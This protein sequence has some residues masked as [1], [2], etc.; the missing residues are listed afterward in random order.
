MYQRMNQWL[1]RMALGLL[2]IALPGCITVVAPTQEPEAQQQPASTSQLTVQANQGWQD[3]GILVQS[4]NILTVKYLSGQ[5]CAWGGGCFDGLGDGDPVNNSVL[6]YAKHASLI[7]RIG[8]NAPFSVGNEY[9]QPASQ[10]GSLSLRMNDVL[11]ND[12]S[13]SITVSITVAR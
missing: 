3:T 6:D 11:L 5:W 1:V 13:G 10:T 9:T 4:G 12:N 7:G 2:I 8:D